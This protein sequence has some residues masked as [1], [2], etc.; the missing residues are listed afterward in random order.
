MFDRETLRL[1]DVGD[2]TRPALFCVGELV[3]MHLRRHRVAMGLAQML[4][5]PQLRVIPNSLI[6]AMWWQFAMAVDGNR[7]YR[8]CGACR[9]W[10]EIAGQAGRTDKLFCSE[11]CKARAHR[12]KQAEARRL[13]QEG[14]T[15]KA[16]AKQLGAEIKTVKG[17]ISK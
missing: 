17:W 8:Q 16:I 4:D 3:N 13:R 1:F 15:A 5:R 14:M 10:Y 7:S 9:K 6:G 2:L 11:S 12:K